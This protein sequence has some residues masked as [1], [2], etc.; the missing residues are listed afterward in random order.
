MVKVDLRKEIEIT[1]ENGHNINIRPIIAQD[2]KG[3][4]IEITSS[5]KTFKENEVPKKSKIIVWANI[6][7]LKN[8]NQSSIS[9]S[10][11]RSNFGKS[12]YELN[13]LTSEEL[14]QNFDIIDEVKI[15]PRDI[16]SYNDRNGYSENFLGEK[17]IVNLPINEKIKRGALIVNDA[18]N[19]VEKYFLKYKNFSII[20]NKSKK[21]AIYTACNV[22]GGQLIS[23]E[24]ENDRWKFDP[25]IE[26][27]YQTGNELY[28]NNP[29]DKGHLVRRLDVVWGN[30]NDAK[31]ANDDTF[32]YTNACPQHKDFNRKP[33]VDL[34]DWILKNADIHDLKLSIF[35]GPVFNE[36]DL[37]YRNSKIP[38]EFWKII[39]MVLK[40]NKLLSATAYLLTQANLIK[41]PKEF[42]FGEYK[43]YQVPIK[44]IIEM[45]NIDFHHLLKFDSLNRIKTFKIP[46]ARIINEYDDIIL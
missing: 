1:Q 25:R 44:K 41:K 7:E 17:F 13:I 24:R 27:K 46:K 8:L 10:I 19:D 6:D 30:E 2:R 18:D 42:S 3:H 23:I 11:N 43:T 31:L 9:D 22:D 36:F 32:H 28:K 35:T 4:L 37:S 5:E 15:L 39:I 20:M 40:Q 29:L 26:K 38:N 21:F 45:T 14:D 16:S 34:E 12:P 33:W